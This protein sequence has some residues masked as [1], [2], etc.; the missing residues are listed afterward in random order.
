[1]APD[2]AAPRPRQAAA[3]RTGL[4][5]ARLIER[6]HRRFLDIVRAELTRLGVGDL[7]P[8]QAMQLLNL[9]DGMLVHDLIERGHYIGSQALY[10]AKKLAQAGYLEL[11]HAPPDRRAL[12]VK[13]TARA[14]ELRIGL[15]TRLE[16][17]PCGVGDDEFTTVQRR[18]RDVARAWDEHLRFGRD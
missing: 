6:L 8:A 4:E 12:R 15:A 16:A 1:M 9:D 11:L 10:N 7:T 18:L 17:V 5:A 13:L 3:T 14:I 2:D